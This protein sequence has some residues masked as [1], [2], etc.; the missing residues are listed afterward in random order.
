[1][2]S[3]G[4]VEA[5][6]PVNES[7]TE[8]VVIDEER[9]NHLPN[10]S[11]VNERRTMRN[12]FGADFPPNTDDPRGKQM[13]DARNDDG[14]DGDDEDTQFYEAAMDDTEDIESDT[15]QIQNPND[16][17]VSDD[18]HGG[19]SNREE[20]D[21]TSGTLDGAE[22]IPLSMGDDPSW[23]I[24]KSQKAGIYMEY[25]GGDLDNTKEAQP[26][27]FPEFPTCYGLTNQMRIFSGVT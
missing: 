10:P 23:Y 16:E 6:E 13:P 25:R 5:R 17:S 21:V 19:S 20:D 8:S 15:D 4:D 3:G 9:R 18:S 26:C 7:R 22:C 24:L 12:R 27:T 2:E 11:N 14:D 1:M